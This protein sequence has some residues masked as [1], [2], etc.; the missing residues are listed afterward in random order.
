MRGPRR[1]RLGRRWLIALVLAPPV[2]WTAVLTFVP[3]DWAR[4][5]IEERVQRMTGC[6]ARL[7]H[8]RFG[9][10]GGVHLTGLSILEPR[11]TPDEVTAPWVE[12]G[13]VRVDLSLGALL[14]GRGEPSRVDVCD[15][16]LRLARDRNGRFPPWL[17]LRNAEPPE[18]SVHDD[19]QGDS[20]SHGPITFR[21]TRG[22]IVFV[23]AQVATTVAIDDLQCSG[24][25]WP[26]VV[27]IED[28]RGGLNGGT[29]ALAAEIE[30]GPSPAF[31]GHLEARGVQLGSNLGLMTYLVPYLAGASDQL[32][33]KLD[34]DLELKGQGASGSDI[35]DSLS[36]RG[37]VRIDPIRLEGSSLLIDLAR[38]LPVTQYGKVG[39]LRSEFSIEDRRILSRKIQLNLG[40][41][42]IVLTGGS[43]FDGR[44]HYQLDTA[45][46]AG[47]VGPDMLALL[48]DAGIT[49]EDLLDLKITGS[50]DQPQVQIGRF[51]I[52]ARQ[53]G[54]STL[55]AITRRLRDRL[56]R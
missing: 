10:L 30:R 42:P 41:T 24:T 15:L 35:R 34:V 18:L 16:S 33:G 21:L 3:T 1:L 6:P 38:V 47:K 2:F 39:S 19:P 9:P 40:G 5:A 54:R 23:D 46:L 4:R 22:R 50:I 55:D 26:S 29:F 20:E 48:A 7:E 14:V 43:A 37:M 56:R 25:W 51:S 28:L 53:E 27:E 11:T 12:A 8:V 44:I 17:L 49:P 13:S 45:P 31:M 32:D 52:D 36:G